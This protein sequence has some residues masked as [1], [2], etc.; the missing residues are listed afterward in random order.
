MTLQLAL[1]FNKKIFKALTELVSIG[2][3]EQQIL[4][5]GWALQSNTSNKESLEADLNKYGSLKKA[6]KGLNQELRN[7]ES[8]T[9]PMEVKRDSIN[10]PK[11]ELHEIT[12]MQEC[13]TLAPLIKAARG[14]KVQVDQL[15]H[16]FTSSMTLAINRIGPDNQLSD[17][18][19]RARDAI[20]EPNIV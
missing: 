16:A 19:R 8:Q 14:E 5:L 12:V 10:I 11:D 18:F 9:R 7:L 20:N 1:G 2:F 6:I 17:V 3:D 13:A 15:K 4:N